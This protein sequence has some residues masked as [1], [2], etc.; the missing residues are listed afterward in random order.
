VGLG[1]L[2]VP[3]WLPILGEDGR[4][5]GGGH[6][7]GIPRCRARHGVRGVLDPGGSGSR[8]GSVVDRPAVIDGTGGWGV[9][10]VSP[11]SRRLN[12][13]RTRMGVGREAEWWKSGSSPVLLRWRSMVGIGSGEPGKSG[14]R[15]LRG[16]R[17]GV[18]SRRSG[19][20]VR[21]RRRSTATL[22]P[23]MLQLLG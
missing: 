8:R 6:T 18:G 12:S 1:G 13:R 2:S 23:Y 3:H 14:M 15:H 21:Q 16:I 22:L 7:V 4:D 11:W 19:R 20:E 17:A 10:E 9:L 5:L